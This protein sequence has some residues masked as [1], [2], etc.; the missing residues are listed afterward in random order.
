M[1]DLCSTPTLTASEASAVSSAYPALTNATSPLPILIPD[2]RS[3][4][5]LNVMTHK[6]VAFTVQA[7]IFSSTRPSTNWET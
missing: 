1:A 7:Q 5:Q 6:R 3:P 2:S 4:N